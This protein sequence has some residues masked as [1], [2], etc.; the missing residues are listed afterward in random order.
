MRPPIRRCRLRLT[1][2][3]RAGR[4]RRVLLNEIDGASSRWKAA[5]PTQRKT[6]SE[7]VDGIGHDLASQF[8]TGAP[9]PQMRVGEVERALQLHV[10]GSDDRPL[11]G[12]RSGL[13]DS[14]PVVG[15]DALIAVH[16]GVRR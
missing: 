13:E 16:L 7:H 14:D 15:R 3:I 2:P 5:I 9:D 6:G 8:G 12:V 1:E 10:A 11:V 4:P